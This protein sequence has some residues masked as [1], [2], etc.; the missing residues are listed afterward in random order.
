MTSWR[1]AIEL[2][3]E[4]EDLG[5]LTSIA[6]S[7]TEAA[8]RDEKPGIQAIATTAPDLPPEPG[9]HATFGR[10]H[11]YK[12]HGTVSLLAGID[13]LTGKVH[14][15]VKDRHRSRY[16]PARAA[17]AAQATGSRR[18]AGEGSGR[19]DGELARHRHAAQRAKHHVARHHPFVQPL[20]LL[21]RRFGN[22]GCAEVEV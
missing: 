21:A 15:L 11:E 22:K 17:F 7:R 14:A 16:Q 9:V 1:R 3:I 2:S 19:R 13:L 8:S 10:D 12:R 20:E 4:E 6:R 18:R 5:R